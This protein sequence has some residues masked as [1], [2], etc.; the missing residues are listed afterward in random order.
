MC[1]ICNSFDPFRP[2][3]AY[4]T[5]S[6]SGANTDTTSDAAVLGSLDDLSSFLMRTWDGGTPRYFHSNT[7]T[8]NLDGLTA[9]GQRLARAAMDAWEMVADIDFVEVA[10]G[11]QITFDDENS[12]AYASYS[13]SGT[14]MI[15]VNVNVSTGWLASY[16][17][18]YDSYSMTTYIHEIGHALGLGH[19][20]NYN[21][22]ATWGTSNTF[23]NDSWQ[24]S[25]MSYFS[26]T[27][28]SYI[29]ASYGYPVTPMMADIRAIQSLYGA[30]GASSATAGNTTYGANTTLTGYLGSLYGFL[31]DGDTDPDLYGGRSV[32]M[33]IYDRDGIDTLDLSTSGSNN[34]VDLMDGTHSDVNGKT[35]NLSIAAGTE[36]EHAIGGSGQDTITG[37]GLNNKIDG[38]GGADL[39]NGRAGADLLEGGTGSDILF[40]GNDND[41]LRGGGDNDKLWG[42]S[43]NDTLRANDGTDTLGG[44]NGNDELWG[45]GSGD[46]LW[47]NGGRDT[48]FGGGGND[49]LGGG[50]GN[51]SLHGG[52]GV[53]DLRGGGGG[54]TLNGGTGNDIL[55]GGANKDIFIFTDGSD[56]ITDFMDD[57]DTIRLDSDLWTGTLTAAQVI[58]GYASVVGGHTVFDFGGG[59]TLQVDTL[60]DPNLLAN[61]LQIA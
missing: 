12:G 13:Y 1:T 23:L 59:N 8:V 37:N 10:S 17:T 7:I 51:D 48:L 30:P 20:G 41:E 27:R 39:L 45:G 16:D 58:A 43:G 56:R 53:D 44:G 54:D 4:D 18:Q 32:V 47:G 19:L 15:S 28:N 3:C 5:D 36:I 21:G 9:D 6:A 55:A 26:Q 40:G 61:D 34:R 31:H 33:T 57:I 49:T 24:M 60:A 38:G 46:K 52:A 11:Q 42:E 22:S 2:D 35:G 50:T 25:I 29:D 14:R